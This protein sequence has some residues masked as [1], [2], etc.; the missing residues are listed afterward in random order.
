VD[1]RVAPRGVAFCGG[2]FSVRGMAEPILLSTWHFGLSANR[3]GWPYLVKE[4]GLLDAL[5]QSCV[6]CVL[7]PAVVSVGLGGLPDAWG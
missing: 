2:G 4:G 1:D 3:A 6:A 7:D 5:E